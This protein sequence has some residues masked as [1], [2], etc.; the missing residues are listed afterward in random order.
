MRQGKEKPKSARTGSGRSQPS[1][2][3]P[4]DDDLDGRLALLEAQISEMRIQNEQ[5]RQQSED[6]V[7]Q[8]KSELEERDSRIKALKDAEVSKFRFDIS[9]PIDSWDNK[10]L[11]QSRNIH[12]FATLKDFDHH[13]IKLQQMLDQ[14]EV[15]IHDC[16]EIVSKF[17]AQRSL[18]GR[19]LQGERGLT[20]TL[21]MERNV[22]IVEQVV[23]IQHFVPILRGRPPYPP[24]T[25]FCH[26]LREVRTRS[27]TKK[28]IPWVHRRFRHWKTAPDRGKE[29][30]NYLPDSYDIE[31][32]YQKPCVSQISSEDCWDVNSSFTSSRSSSSITHDKQSPASSPPQIS[33]G[34]EGHHSTFGSG[35]P[36]THDRGDPTRCRSPIPQRSFSPEHLHGRIRLP[37]LGNHHPQEWPVSRDNIQVHGRGGPVAHQCQGIDGVGSTLSARHSKTSLNCEFPLEDQQR[38]PSGSFIPQERGRQDG[39][40]EQHGRKDCS[41]SLATRN[42]LVGTRLHSN[43]LQSSGCSLKSCGSG[44]LDNINPGTEPGPQSCRLL[45][46]RP[47]CM[48]HHEKCNQIFHSVGMSKQCRDQCVGVKLGQQ[49]LGGPTFLSSRPHNLLFDRKWSACYASGSKLVRSLA[50]CLSGWGELCYSSRREGQR[51]RETSVWDDG[52]NRD[53]RVWRDGWGRV[54]DDSVL[55]EVSRDPLETKTRQAYSDE[56]FSAQTATVYCFPAPPPKNLSHVFFVVCKCLSDFLISALCFLLGFF[57]MSHHCT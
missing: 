57:P 25:R 11:T 51:H 15:D 16:T 2:E 55:P 45:D 27:L 49:C 8:Y 9:K 37:G 53:L 35:D 50:F 54:V 19:K 31:G 48:Q 14:E 1:S 23:I 38:Q 13:L 4:Q 34:Q 17:I 21:L 3:L 41:E 6:Q 26:K 18:H 42:P 56:S 5:I 10:P 36:G 7:R 32:H 39:T 47:V 12:E 40:S 28:K 30:K 22:T 44:G 24:V 46:D 52:A 29:G 33:V 43:S 20:S